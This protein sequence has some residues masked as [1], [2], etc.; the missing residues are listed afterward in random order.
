[1]QYED[2]LDQNLKDPSE[3]RHYLNAALADGDQQVFLLAL[4][5]VARAWGISSLFC[6]LSTS[7]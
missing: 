6:H 2:Y 4:N 7:D 5:D 1:M 3:A